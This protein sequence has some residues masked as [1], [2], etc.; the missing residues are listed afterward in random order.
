MGQELSGKVAVVTGG[1]KGIGRATVELFVAEGASV[2]IADVD[3]DHGEA[4]AAELGER[5][6]FQHTDTGDRDSM[7]AAIA[8]AVD[9][10]GGLHVMYN[11]AGISGV[12]RRFLKDSL[13]DFER[14]I[15]VDLLGV[16]VGCQAAA[17]H[18]AEHGG[19]S[20]IN[21][22]SIAGLTP[23]SGVT[24]Y[25]VAKAG[26]IHLTRCLSIDLAEHGI[27]VNC[28]APANIPTGINAQFDI[29]RTIQLTQP[30]QRVGSPSD[31]AQAVLFL[32][33][34]RSAQITGV[35]LPVDGGTS[36]GPPVSR[37]REVMNVRRPS[38]S[39]Q[40]PDGS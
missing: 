35:V 29:D 23:G 24:A 39:P 17:R 16:M 33:G 36:V 30:L 8:T 6:A 22:T 3:D 37:L 32:A 34:D 19:G 40:T 31:A 26:V 15:A 27:R 18:M 7:R 25:R 14:V 11:N 5:A 9:H 21:T 10:F 4:L 28:V 2:V 1:A 38:V 20:I 12:P 13:D